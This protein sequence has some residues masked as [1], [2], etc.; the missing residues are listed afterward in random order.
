METYDL[1]QMYLVENLSG[2]YTD[3]HVCDYNLNGSI[4]K[5]RYSCNPNYYWDK[6]YISYDNTLEV[7]ILDY[8]T[9]VYNKC[10][11]NK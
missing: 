9:W 5:I 3:I 4:I 2:D 7:D 8:M 6:N 11:T 1:V 10:L